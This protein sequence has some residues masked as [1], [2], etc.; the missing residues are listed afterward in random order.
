MLVLIGDDGEGDS[1]DLART[2]TLDMIAKG[3]LWSGDRSA[4]GEFTG[5]GD[6]VRDDQVVGYTMGTPKVRKGEST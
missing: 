3:V 6:I 2:I 4:Q 5:A 1:V